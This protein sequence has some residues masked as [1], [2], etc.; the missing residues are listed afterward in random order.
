MALGKSKKLG[1]RDIANIPFI[2]LAWRNQ[3]AR[4]QAAQ[5]FGGNRVVLIVVGGDQAVVGGHIVRQTLTN[6]PPIWRVV[7]FRAPGVKPLQ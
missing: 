5:P 2:D 3:A 4:D 1:W 7:N 6:S